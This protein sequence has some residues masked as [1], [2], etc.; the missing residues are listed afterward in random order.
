MTDSDRNLQNTDLLLKSVTGEPLDII[1]TSDMSVTLT[2]DLTVTHRFLVVRNLQPYEAILGL[3]FLSHP[4]HNIR[5]D[6]ANFLLH[7]QGIPI[8]LFD[9]KRDQP[10]STLTPVTAVG[11]HQYLAPHAITF[12]KVQIREDPVKEKLPTST[13]TKTDYV[14]FHPRRQKDGEPRIL[15]GVFDAKQMKEGPLLV[16]VVNDTH[17]GRTL[18]MGRI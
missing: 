11:R 18:K 7:V 12:V 9:A 4:R 8:R 6:L 13:L 15:G 16:G 17:I 3:D 5:H 1:G 10:C 2:P 14:E